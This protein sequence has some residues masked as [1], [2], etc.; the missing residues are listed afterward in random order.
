MKKYF[1]ILG[2]LLISA[3]FVVA[4]PW[5]PGKIVTPV[6]YSIVP[7]V[8]DITVYGNADLAPIM[9]PVFLPG[10]VLDYKNY[11]STPPSTPLRVTLLSVT[12]HLSLTMDVGW[13]YYSTSVTQLNYPMKT[14]PAITEI[15]NRRIRELT[16]Q[17]K[18]VIFNYSNSP[19]LLFWCIDPID[20]TLITSFSGPSRLI[21]PQCRT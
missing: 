11:A 18:T 7:M 10:E 17:D 4:S 14:C 19:P 6:E 13:R 8:Q 5:P 3:A 2:L 9:Q 21:N 20:K 16:C 15:W 12:E 1:S